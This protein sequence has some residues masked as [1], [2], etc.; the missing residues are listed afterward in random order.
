MT[1]KKLK[2]FFCIPNL[3][4]GGA[5][6][7]M[8]FLAKNLSSELF[9]VKL[10]VLGF[11]KDTVYSTGG[12][13]VC[14]LN[15]DKAQNAFVKI[16]QLIKEYKPDILFGTLTHINQIVGLLSYLFPKMVCVTRQTFIISEAKKSVKQQNWFVRTKN[17]ILRKLAH[18]RIDYTI[19]QSNDM[20]NDMLDS[21]VY[22][23]RKLVVLNNPVSNEIRTKKE[24]LPKKPI[25][26]ITVGRLNKQKGY[27]RIITCLSKIN[28]NFTYT[29]IG[30]GPRKESLFGLA[31]NLGVLERINHIP[32]SNEVYQHLSEHHIYLQGS[33]Y[34]GFPNALLESLGVGTPAI[35]YEAPG[36]MNEIMIDGEN[37]YLVKNDT[38]FVEKLQLLVMELDSFP[39]SQ[40]SKHV[41]KNFGS[42]KII[43]DYENFFTWITREKKGELPRN[44]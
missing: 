27:D 11:E 41:L 17:E 9:S 15:E 8:V 23:S 39:P 1:Q 24:I 33:L 19:C 7:V 20:K 26:F 29:I 10:I 5:E 18:K 21:G 42:K 2:I 31:E 16:Y 13:D 22:D 30:D 40:V 14:Y 38:D 36:G 32:F 37:G 3:S 25:K 12:V 4:A 35:V 6:R 43:S 28:V 44:I 34:E